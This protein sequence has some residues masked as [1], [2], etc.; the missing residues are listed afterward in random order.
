MKIYITAIPAANLDDIYLTVEG[1]DRLLKVIAPLCE[2]D[3]IQFI[4]E[5]A[6]ATYGCF[7]D[8]AMAIQGVGSAAGALTFTTLTDDGNYLYNSISPTDISQFKKGNN[9]LLPISAKAVTRMTPNIVTSSVPTL[10]GTTAAVWSATHYHFYATED[11]NPLGATS[12][13][14]YTFNIGG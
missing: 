5:T 12:V 14:V 4:E 7:L 9:Y 1:K 10:A 3:S 6:G 2:P 13:S 8:L 11:F